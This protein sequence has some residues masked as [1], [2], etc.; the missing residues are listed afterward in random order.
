MGLDDTSC[1]TSEMALEQLRKELIDLFVQFE[2]SLSLCDERDK[3]IRDEARIFKEAY[4]AEK[5]SRKKT[6]S[7]LDDVRLELDNIRHQQSLQ[8]MKNFHERREAALEYY[9][10]KYDEKAD[11]C[12]CGR[13]DCGEDEID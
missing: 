9:R 3:L 4:E 1:I 8:A 6:Q 13:N 7:E 2:H 5:L 11:E 10:R 12:D